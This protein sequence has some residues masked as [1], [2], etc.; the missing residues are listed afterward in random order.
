MVI[1]TEM[2]DDELTKAVVGELPESQL[3]AIVNV[4]GAVCVFQLNCVR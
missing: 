3:R 1:T 4:K 2:L